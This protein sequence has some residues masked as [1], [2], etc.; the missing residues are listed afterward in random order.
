LPL[1]VPAVA[2]DLSSASLLC[3]NCA[4]VTTVWRYAKQDNCVLYGD[5][6]FAIANL[7]HLM[8]DAGDTN[9]LYL[10]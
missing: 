6:A 3:A 4:L 10:L 9:A 5:S 1:I 2:L 7:N 8:I